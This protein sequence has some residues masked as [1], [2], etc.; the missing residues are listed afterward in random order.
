MSF[1]DF[2]AKLPLDIL[3]QVELSETRIIIPCP[4]DANAFYQ[5]FSTDIE[6]ETLTDEKAIYIASS[7]IPKPFIT[8][9]QLLNSKLQFN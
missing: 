9:E 5:T 4:I 3:R 6:A 2:L 7:H 8:A 1:N